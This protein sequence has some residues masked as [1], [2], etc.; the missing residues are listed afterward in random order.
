M[1][2]LTSLPVAPEFVE[3]LEDTASKT[4]VEYLIRTKAPD[5]II[6]LVRNIADLDYYLIECQTHPEYFQGERRDRF[7]I[8]GLVIES[9]NAIVR[10]GG[11]FHGPYLNSVVREVPLPVKAKK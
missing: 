4:V 3:V 5:V 10:S 8:E 6:Q 9:V 1:S 2:D 7:D 11:E